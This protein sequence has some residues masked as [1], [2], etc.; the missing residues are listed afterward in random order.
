MQRDYDLVLEVNVPKHPNCPSCALLHKQLQ[1]V[2]I[3]LLQQNATEIFV[4]S[5]NI[6][7][8]REHLGVFG[9]ERA[10]ALIYLKRGKPIRGK[11][12]LMKVEEW[13][14]D[15]DYMVQWVNR[16]SPTQ[17][18]SLKP[19]YQHANVQYGILYTLLAIILIQV[20][21]LRKVLFQHRLSW[22]I[23]VCMVYLL[24]M[25]GHVWNKINQPP[26]LPMGNS[27]V[28]PDNM[29]AQFGIEGYLMSFFLLMLSFCFICI[30]DVDVIRATRL[31]SMRYVLFLAVFMLVTM[32]HLMY[33]NVFAIKFRAYPFQP[34]LSHLLVPFQKAFAQTS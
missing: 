5:L 34:K 11:F 3:A 1:Q 17:I 18:A 29:R 6:E 8:L 12:E 2:R 27:L 31:V 28:L 30:G 24:S 21:R 19:F 32:M 25:S 15:I 16:Y 13:N 14:L 20:V 33:V 26:Y 4:V 7:E 10:P 23:L 9:L 22:Y